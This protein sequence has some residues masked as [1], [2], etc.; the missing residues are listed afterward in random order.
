LGGP[1]GDDPHPRRRALR[2]GPAAPAIRPLPHRDAVPGRAAGPQADDRRL[3]GLVALVRRAG[4]A[5]EPDRRGP[6]RRGGGAARGP[7]A[8]PQ[9]LPP[10]P[11]HAKSPSPAANAPG[12]GRPPPR[13]RTSRRGASR[14]SRTR[15]TMPVIQ[16]S[17]PSESRTVSDRGTSF[18]PAPV[19]PP[20]SM[21]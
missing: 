6:P 7:G 20:H 12:A 9:G 1:R 16:A 2:R 3:S 8:P 15:G 11:T 17:F 4:H 10:R 14:L 21:K 18:G 19:I 13:P 5:D